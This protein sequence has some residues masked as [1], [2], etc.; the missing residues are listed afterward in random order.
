MA[1]QTQ[2]LFDSATITGYLFPCPYDKLARFAGNL[3]TCL[4]AGVGV[5]KSLENANRSLARTPLA[6]ALRVSLS[7]VAKGSTLAEALAAIEWGLPPFFLPMIQAGEQTGRVDEALRYLE[8][9]CRLLIEPTKALRNVWLIPLAIM[10]FGTVIQLAAHILFTPWTA[11]L[12]F[13][14][15]SLTSYAM[16]L[17]LAFIVVSSPAKPIIDQLKLLLPIVRDVERESAVNHFFHALAMLYSV[18]GRRVESMIT[19]SA[20]LVGNVVIQQDLRAVGGR[21]E[22]GDTIPEAF[23]TSRHLSQPE[24]DLIESGDISGTLERSFELI[25]KDAGETLRFRLGIFQQLF[26]RLMTGFI[27]FSIAMTMVSLIRFV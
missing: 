8:R 1:R 18:G 11:T 15:S 10:L 21:I 13:V 20:R 26:T 4:E 2:S 25:S 19:L 7:R 3:A 6:P 22:K 16:L 17:V 23:R 9:H 24:Q 14:F 12:S 5:E 27:V